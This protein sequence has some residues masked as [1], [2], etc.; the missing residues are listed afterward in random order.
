MLTED[1]YIYSRSTTSVEI[2]TDLLRKEMHF[3][4]TEKILDFT[5][6][7]QKAALHS[8][9]W[10]SRQIPK[11]PIILVSAFFSSLQF[12]TKRSQRAMNKMWHTLKSRSTALYRITKN[13]GTPW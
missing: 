1:K 5:E 2:A 9:I 10:Y 8:G 12:T 11:N 7:A 13:G 3:M 6:T 4:T